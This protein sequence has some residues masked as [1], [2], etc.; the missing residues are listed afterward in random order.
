LGLYSGGRASP[1]SEREAL[2]SLDDERDPGGDS[3]SQET[4]GQ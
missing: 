2:S 3:A 1:I 4:T